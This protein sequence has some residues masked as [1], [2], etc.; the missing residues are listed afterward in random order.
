[1]A[2]LG[3]YRIHCAGWGTAM[4]SISSAFVTQQVLIVAAST[5]LGSDCQRIMTSEQQ[6]TRHI[7]TRCRSKERRRSTNSR[8]QPNITLPKNFSRSTEGHLRDRRT[9][10]LHLGSPLQED[11]VQKLL[12]GQSLYSCLPLPIFKVEMFRCLFRVRRSGQ[13][14][15]PFHKDS[16]SHSLH[17]RLQLHGGKQTHNRPL[18]ANLRPTPS[19][20]RLNMHRLGMVH[21]GMIVSWTFCSAKT[22]PVRKIG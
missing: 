17:P 2:Q 15:L 13:R 18:V 7:W 5:W 9:E 19:H 14:P 11:P 20:L 21:G 12:R 22:N 6:A 4:V 16:Y 3:R 8:Q 1:M 10:L